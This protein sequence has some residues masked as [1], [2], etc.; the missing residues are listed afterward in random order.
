MA[1]YEYLCDD[2]KKTF[3]LTQLISEHDEAGKAPKCPECGGSNT[4]QLF[5][6]FFPK[7]STKS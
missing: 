4:H 3:T 2:C 5:S 6:T 1:I 7:T